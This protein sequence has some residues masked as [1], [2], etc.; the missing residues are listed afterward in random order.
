[1]KKTNYLIAGTVIF[2]LSQGIMAHEVT[3]EKIGLHVTEQKMSLLGQTRAMAKKVMSDIHDARHKLFKLQDEHSYYPIKL[4]NKALSH[5]KIG[6]EDISDKDKT[7][8]EDDYV[9]FDSVVNVDNV[10]YLN[11]F[12]RSARDEINKNTEVGDKKCVSEKLK[13]ASSDVNEILAI[14]PVMHTQVDLE[15]TE[16]LI[17]TEK[18]YEE[19]ATH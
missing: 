2:V 3:K 4:A 7:Q 11:P 18:Y 15:S 9:M 12:A 17:N 10:F 8:G 14:L 6:G 5:A 1:M 13:R 19:N 16:N